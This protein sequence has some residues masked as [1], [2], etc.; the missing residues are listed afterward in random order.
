VLD[1][2]QFA[3]LYTKKYHRFG[4][5]TMS[6]VMTKLAVSALLVATAL[7]ATSSRSLHYSSFK[8]NVSGA[9]LR[10]LQCLFSGVFVLPVILII[11]PSPFLLMHRLGSTHPPFVLLFSLV[12][13]YETHLYLTWI[14]LTQSASRTPGLKGHRKLT[15]FPDRDRV[16]AVSVS[17]SGTTGGAASSAGSVMVTTGTAQVSIM[18]TFGSTSSGT[19]SSSSGSPD[20]TTTSGDTAGGSSGA[21]VGSVE[22]ST[23]TGTTSFDII[24][25]ATGAGDFEATSG[26]DAGSTGA[27]S[28]SVAVTST[29]TGDSIDTGSSTASAEA[30]G[31][32]RGDESEVALSES[33]MIQ[34][35]NDAVIASFN[36][37][38]ISRPNRVVSRPNRIFGIRAGVKRVFTRAP[39]ASIINDAP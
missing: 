31:G 34:G 13:R 14:G 16:N 32:G 2:P 8:N 18:G 1:I 19:G 26:P 12:T 36:D 30:S 37:R 3:P 39:R 22:I 15:V 24:A 27:G 10:S 29:G 20:C 6:S 4:N 17:G 9:E 38:A 7:V 28:G 23:P 33:V 21:T 5:I 11:G 35:F 25:E